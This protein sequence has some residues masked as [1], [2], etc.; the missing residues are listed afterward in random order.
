M[1]AFTAS[2]VIGNKR[3]RAPL[4][5]NPI[6]W[7]SRLCAAAGLCHELVNRGRKTAGAPSVSAFPN[8]ERIALG[9]GLGRDYAAALGNRDADNQL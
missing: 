6:F 9:W 7:K 1:L 8:R 5:E 3:M 2:A 4:E